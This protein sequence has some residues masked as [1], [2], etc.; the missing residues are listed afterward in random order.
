MNPQLYFPIPAYLNKALNLSY[1]ELLEILDLI[2]H[3][4]ESYRS[5]NKDMVRKL[6]DRYLTASNCSTLYYKSTR[7][8]TMDNREKKKPPVYP[9]ENV[10]IP[11]PVNS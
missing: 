8:N 10:I 3:E 2:N 6:S 9:V 11:E 4:V 5:V 1:Y 7:K